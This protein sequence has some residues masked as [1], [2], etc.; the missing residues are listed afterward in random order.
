MVEET[1]IKKL[2]IGLAAAGALFGAALLF[3]FATSGDDED[4]S[5]AGLD[6][7]KLL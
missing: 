1:N 2:W 4:G 5:G 3:H 6:S 7:D